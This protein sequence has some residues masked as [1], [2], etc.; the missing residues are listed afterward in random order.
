MPGAEIRYAR[1]LDGLRP[2]R[3]RRLGDPRGGGTHHSYR[4]RL[5]VGRLYLRVPRG[6]PAAGPCGHTLG[7]RLLLTRQPAVFAAPV[8]PAWFTGWR[9]AQEQ[10]AAA[11]TLVAFSAE[12]WHD[13]TPWSVEQ[14]LQCP[15]SLALLAHQQRVVE[16]LARWLR[17]LVAEG[18]QHV[19]RGE[20]DYSQLELSPWQQQ[21]YTLLNWELLGLAE[22]VRTLAGQCT[23]EELSEAS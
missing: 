14:I 13:P 10:A 12:R 9:T 15:E 18:L 2:K 6:R 7:L 22:A 3:D 21:E 19:P 5:Y 4:F 1:L 11:G 23:G 8:P 16:A 17:D 20:M